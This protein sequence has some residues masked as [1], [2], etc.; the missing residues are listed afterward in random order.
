MKQ[1]TKRQRFWLFSFLDVFFALVIPSILIAFQYD[2][3]TN[4]ADKAEMSA[5]GWGMIVILFIALG[6]SKRIKAYVVSSKNSQLKYFLSNIMP[7]FVLL[8]LYFILMITENHIDKL[9][10]ITLWASI[11]NAIAL[12]FRLFAGK[13]I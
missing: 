6:L 7:P 11:S 4:R 13:E 8:F 5:S 1:L 10:I 9:Q 12:V 3:F 2:L